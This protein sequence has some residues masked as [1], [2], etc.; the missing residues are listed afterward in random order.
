MVNLVSLMARFDGDASGFAAAS[1][2][3]RRELN[4]FGAQAQRAQTQARAAFGGI[5]TAWQS[6]VGVLAT[7]GVGLGLQQMVSDAAQFERQI[8]IIAATSGA[9]AGDMRALEGT[10]RRVGLEFGVGGRAAARAAQE[11][12]KSGIAIEDINAGA[13]DSA[14]TLAVAL[15]GDYADAASVA[16]TALQVFREEAERLPDII[17]GVTGTV[18]GGRFELND[19]TLALQQGGGAA[20]A[21]GIQLEDFNAALLLIQRN[22]GSSGSDTGTALRTFIARLTPQS[23]EAAAAMERL[24]LAFF[25]AQG[26]FIG[27]EESAERIRRAFAGLSDQQRNLDFYQ[28]FGVDAARVAQA[29]YNEGAAG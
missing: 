25:D 14:V 11:L 13:L 28:I 22:I 16:A 26:R 17:Q 27:L 21:A 7:V 3:A 1:A 6:A 24:G 15:G 8:R 9:T 29:L 12:Q 19:Y 5:A 2:V 23:E 18:L 10:I 4:S 20:A